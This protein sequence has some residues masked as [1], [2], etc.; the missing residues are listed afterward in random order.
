MYDHRRGPVW[1]PKGSLS[2]ILPGRAGPLLTGP[3][4][5]MPF[6]DHTGPREIVLIEK[7]C[8]RG[9][10]RVACEAGSEMSHVTER[11]ESELS[12]RITQ[13]LSG[14]V[15]A[16]AATMFITQTLKLCTA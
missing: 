13:H 2:L 4:M 10:K 14:R 12:T 11:Q 6:G 16:P 15:R 5:A 7:P 1:S 3:R 9:S 8:D